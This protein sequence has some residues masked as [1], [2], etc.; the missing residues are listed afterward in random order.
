[1]CI[2]PTVIFSFNNS[3]SVSVSV[4]FSTGFSLN[5]LSFGRYQFLCDSVFFLEHDNILKMLR[6]AWRDLILTLECGWLIIF[7]SFSREKKQPPNPARRSLS[8]KCRTNKSDTNSQ[9]STQS[10]RLRTRWKRQNGSID[11]LKSISNHNERLLFASFYGV[12]SL[13]NSV[14]LALASNLSHNL[15]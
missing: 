6:N 8:S 1:M 15:A 14:A 9:T 3:S 7:L 11:P 10:I 13:N 5:G 4:C 12:F 2:W